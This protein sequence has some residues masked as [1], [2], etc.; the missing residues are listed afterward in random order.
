MKYIYFI[1]GLLFTGIGCIGIVLPI[2]PTT[3]FLLLALFLFTKSSKRA[4]TWF[5]STKI[6]QK[7]IDSFVKERAMTLKSKIMIL[8]FAS[9]MLMIAFFMMDNLY[10]RLTIV[11]LIFFKYYYFIFRIKTI[12]NEVRV[13]YD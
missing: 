4:E 9:S 2:L 1:L 6:Y 3:P 12:K 11:A 5:K 7:H 10:G 13:K 8:S